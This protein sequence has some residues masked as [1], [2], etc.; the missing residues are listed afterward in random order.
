MTARPSSSDC[1]RVRHNLYGF[2]N[3]VDN[4]SSYENEMYTFNVQRYRK[5][6]IDVISDIH[7]RGKVPIVCG[8]TNYYIESLLFEETTS[9]EN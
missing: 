3:A 1:E 5:M 7:S 2:L 9:N 8:G 6:A 4:A